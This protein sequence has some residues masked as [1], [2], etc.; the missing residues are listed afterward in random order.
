MVV[1]STP[2]AS[3]MPAG[4]A[5]LPLESP[6]TPVTALFQLAELLLTLAAGPCVPPRVVSSP[7]AHHVTEHAVL[8]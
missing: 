6:S 4:L 7:A 8:H 3:P 2:L 5:V 1:S